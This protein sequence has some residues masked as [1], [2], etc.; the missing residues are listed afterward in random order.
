MRTLLLFVLLSICVNLDAQYFQRY[1][2]EVVTAQ[3][4]RVEAFGD[5]LKSRANYG[6]GIPTKY[7]F[8]ATGS[9]ELSPA[10]PTGTDAAFTVRA[11]QFEWHCSRELWVPVWR[12]FAKMV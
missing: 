12:R 1:F 5:G 10:P 9:S 2:N 4:K 11:H 3:P 8:A 6:G 7:Y